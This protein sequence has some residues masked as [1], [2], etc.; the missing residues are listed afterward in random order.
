MVYSPDRLAEQYVKPADRVRDIGCGPGSFTR[1]FARGSRA[2]F[3]PELAG[4]NRLWG[5]L[6]LFESSNIF[7]LSC[8]YMNF[9]GRTY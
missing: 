4:Q 6:P 3:S 1:E 7:Q 2:V 9:Y 8:Y 5:T